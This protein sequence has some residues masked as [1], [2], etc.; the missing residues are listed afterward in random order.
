MQQLLSSLAAI[1]F[2]ALVATGCAMDTQDPQPAPT[3]RTNNGWAE[4]SP[5]IPS[6]ASSEA[7]DAGH[8]VYGMSDPVVEGSGGEWC[9]DGTTMDPTTKQCVPID[10]AAHQP[11][12]VAPPH[13]PH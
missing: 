12:F 4:E 7:S 5:T 10:M 13:H 6:T 11:S 8:P 9:P 2:A 3:P 1:A